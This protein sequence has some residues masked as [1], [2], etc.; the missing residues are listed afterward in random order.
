MLTED[1]AV[2]EAKRALLAF[3]AAVEPGEDGRQAGALS[4]R[5]SPFARGQKDWNDLSSN[6]DKEMQHV[7]FASV[8][9]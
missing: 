5:L 1:I 4:P 9:I 2:L 7:I 8:K 3:I 6:D